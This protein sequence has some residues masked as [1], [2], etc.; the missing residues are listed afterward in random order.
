MFEISFIILFHRTMNVF[1]SSGCYVRRY[2]TDHPF[3]RPTVIINAFHACMGFKVN[4]FIATN[5]L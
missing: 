5:N 4:G 2:G 3:G 1:L